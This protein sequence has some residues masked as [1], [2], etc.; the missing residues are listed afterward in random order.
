[1][2]LILVLFLIVIVFISGCISKTVSYTRQK[3]IDECKERCPTGIAGY[4]CKEFCVL[5]VDSAI[6]RTKEF[7]T[8]LVK[9]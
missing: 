4:I 6:N 9:R 1:M 5:G 8:G 2:K 3:A 7:I